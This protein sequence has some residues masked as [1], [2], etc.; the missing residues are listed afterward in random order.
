MTYGLIA[1]I[2]LLLNFTTILKENYILNPI[3]LKTDYEISKTNKIKF[4]SFKSKKLNSINK[5]TK[6]DLNTFKLND[7]GV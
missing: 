1:T 5:K 6:L 4:Y 7:F 2:G 3:V